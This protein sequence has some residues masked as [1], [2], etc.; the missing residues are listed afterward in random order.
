M[1]EVVYNFIGKK[2]VVTG[3]SSGMGRQV[4]IELVEAGASVL[5]IAR[6]ENKLK[7]LVALY[8]EKIQYSLCDVRNK[9]NLECAIANFVKAY[10]KINGCVH[11]A[12]I[13]GLTPLKMFDNDFA[14]DI[15]DVSFWAGVSL[16]QIVTKN[17]YSEIGSSSVLFSSAGAH[18]AEKGMFAYASTKAAMQ[19]AVRSIAKEISNKGHR[20]NTISPGWVKTMMTEN[21]DKTIDVN[22]IIEQHLL[23]A[24]SPKDVSGMVLFLLSD[25]AKWITG[26]DVIVDG[27]Y[28]A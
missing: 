10:G 20:V 15:M 3:A 17:R 27:G 13:L 23:G 21:T 5:A 9:E 22:F 4:V 24:G 26:T 25:R 28:L 18:S 2:F 16:I 19:V 8:P 7:E 11:A 6:N 14:H 1:K 12:G